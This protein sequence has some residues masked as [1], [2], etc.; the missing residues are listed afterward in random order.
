MSRKHTNILQKILL[1]SFQV[2]FKALQMRS[3][4][5]MFFFFFI[6]VQ[7]PYKLSHSSPSPSAKQI[8]CWS[9][10]AQA[11]LKLYCL[12]APVSG[13][14]PMVHF[15]TLWTVVMCSFLWRALW[16]WHS[17][18]NK[19]L[20]LLGLV[21]HS[22]HQLITSPAYTLPLNGTP[23]TFSSLSLQYELTMSGLEIG[24]G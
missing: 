19:S 10:C 8:W 24:N 2:L 17:C 20:V 14:E 13:A 3:K 15:F 22:L 12:Q 4:C 21:S 9:G 5:W 6:T 1:L 11:I 16:K 23:S 7:P 18:T